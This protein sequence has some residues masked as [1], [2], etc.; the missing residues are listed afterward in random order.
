MK[1]ANV[2]KLV[3]LGGCAAEPA[4]EVIG[5]NSVAT[6]QI[7][8]TT[9]TTIRVNGRSAFTFLTDADTN[10]SL[11]ASRDEIAN[12]KALDFGYASSDPTNPDLIIFINGAGAIPNSS[13]QVS[14]TSAELHVTTSFPVTRCVFNQITGE[15]TCGASPPIRFDLSW[16]GDGFQSVKEFV[17][18]KEKLGPTTTKFEAD[19]KLWSAVVN[20][21]WTGNVASNNSGNLQD[22]EN[23]TVTREITMTP[24][25]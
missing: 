20:G 12:T 23:V 2:C 21:T 15:Q 10:G 19:N 5:Q 24:T 8:A 13:F 4:T 22:T 18:R 14:H 17:R 9:V 7:G 25:P 6:T 11:T 1:M 3:L 16:V